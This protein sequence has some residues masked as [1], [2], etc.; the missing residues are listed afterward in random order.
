M[1][2]LRCWESH[3]TQTLFNFDVLNV[4]LRPHCFFC[5][6]DGKPVFTPPFLDAYLLF[7]QDYF[8]LGAAEPPDFSCLLAVIGKVQN[9]GEASSPPSANFIKVMGS[10][11][12][13]DKEIYHIGR[14]TLIGSAQLNRI[15]G[16][17][18]VNSGL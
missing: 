17:L 7:F 8:R 3:Q 2:A 6:S 13:S 18:D 14:V 5:G 12:L 10:S 15:G 11:R 9:Q 16:F 4:H 1:F